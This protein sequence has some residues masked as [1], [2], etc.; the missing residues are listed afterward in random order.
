MGR[1]VCFNTERS[2]FESSQKDESRAL[3]ADS[4]KT[5]RNPKSLNCWLLFFILFYL[6][7]VQSVTDD[8]STALHIIAKYKQRFLSMEHDVNGKVSISTITGEK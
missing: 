7:D 6:T 8:D 3:S 4:S 5:Y 1:V 2:K